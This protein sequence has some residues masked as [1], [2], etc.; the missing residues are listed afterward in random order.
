MSLEQVLD[1]TF[2]VWLD[3]F[4][5][6]ISDDE[7]ASKIWTGFKYALAL[8][9]K[10]GEKKAEKEYEKAHRR[11]SKPANKIQKLCEERRSGFFS[12]QGK[13]Y[14]CIGIFDPEEWQE[15]VPITREILEEKRMKRYKKLPPKHKKMVE[16]VLNGFPFDRIVFWDCEHGKAW[17][18]F[19]KGCYGEGRGKYFTVEE[20]KCTV[21]YKK[22]MNLAFYVHKEKKP[23]RLWSVDECIEQIL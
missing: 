6:E 10:E 21:G 9:R 11:Y 1:E 18:T 15:D 14:S 16:F 19:D 7:D 12:Y 23:V 3:S 8:V 17:F 2:Q 5:G 20:G 4:Q 22:G 13:V